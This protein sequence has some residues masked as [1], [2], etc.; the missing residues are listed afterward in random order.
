VEIINFLTFFKA[1][2][3]A[4]EIPLKEAIWATFFDTEKDT[5]PVQ[6]PNS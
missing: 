3:N 1:L 5:M 2:I 4:A 6:K